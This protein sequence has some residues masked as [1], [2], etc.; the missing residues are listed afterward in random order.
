MLGGTTVTNTGP[1]LITGDQGVSSPGVRVA[2]AC[3]LAVAHTPKG[4]IL[5]PPTWARPN[6]A[7]AAATPAIVAGAT[8][9]RA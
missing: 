1:S 9:R 3:R 6:S 7:L 8:R 5:R 2:T 4:S